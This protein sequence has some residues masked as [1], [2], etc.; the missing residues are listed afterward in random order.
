MKSQYPFILVHGVALKDF[1]FFKAFGRIGKMLEK[2]GYRVYTARTDAF[3]TIE[4]NAAQLKA[5][6]EKLLRDTGAEKVN[7]IAHSKGGLDARYMI[8]HLG[9]EGKVASLTTLCTPHRGSALASRILRLPEF[10]LHILDFFF[11]LVY[12]IGG[13]KHPSALAVCRQLKAVPAEEWKNLHVSDEVYCQSYSAVLEE[14]RADFVRDVPLMYFRSFQ[15]GPSDGMVSV[16]SAKYGN[17][18][19][20]CL[21][22]SVSHSEIV[23]LMTKKKKKEKIFGFYRNLCADL[24]ERGF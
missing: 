24:A 22:E 20:D 13:D 11:N 3:G 14:K 17:Y 9:M 21:E 10:V 12:R 19:G 18:R 8:E 2:E 5:E 16:E 4:T 15:D 23:D 6:T 7:I 1:L